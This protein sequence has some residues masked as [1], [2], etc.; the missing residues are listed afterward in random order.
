MDAR[1]KLYRLL[2]GWEI[3]C[4]LFLAVWIYFIYVQFQ[5][6]TLSCF[7]FFLLLAYTLFLMVQYSIISG[8][9]KCSTQNSVRIGLLIGIVACM[10]PV[11]SI[12]AFLSIRY[13]SD[14]MKNP[15]NLDEIE[16]KKQ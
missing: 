2:K 11:G 1:V 7:T 9:P 6:S 5:E 10:I 8:I 14:A 12:V 4:Y 15:S 3:F 16:E 13:L